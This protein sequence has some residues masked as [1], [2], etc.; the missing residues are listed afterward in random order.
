MSFQSVGFLFDG[1]YSYILQL[2]KHKKPPILDKQYI[3]C[4]EPSKI[5]IK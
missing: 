2:Y 1:I 4:K 3:S 5:G